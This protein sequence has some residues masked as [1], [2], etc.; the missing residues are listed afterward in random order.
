MIR[1][2][3]LQNKIHQPLKM[4]MMINQRQLHQ[5][6]KK[7]EAVA[8]DSSSSTV[9]NNHQQNKWNTT[10]YTSKMK[11]IDSMSDLKAYRVLTKEGDV[12]DPQHEP[13]DLTKDDLIHA[14]STMV[15]LHRMDHIMYEAQRQGRFSFYMTTFGEEA[16]IGVPMALDFKDMIHG[17][18]R[19]AYSLLYRGFSISD[20]MN[21]CFSNKDDGGK[22]RQ[23]MVHYTSKECNFQAIS[24]PLGTQIP[25]AS[26]VG[27][28]FKLNANNDR[29][30]VAFFG[31]GA[32]SEG[33]FHAGLNMAATLNCPVLFFCR[34]NGYAISTSTKEQYKGDGIASRGVGYGIDTIRV[35][36]NDVLAV[37][38]ATKAARQIAIQENKPVLI[39]AMTYRVGHHSTSDDS[40]KYR[41]RKEVEQ[42][43]ISDNPIHRF[44]N[45]LEKKNYW[46]QQKEDD[47]QLKVKQQVMEAFKIAE[48]KKKPNI[49]E[50]FTDVY[51]EL[52]PHLIRQKN[53]LYQLMKK[54]PEYYNTDDYEK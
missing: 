37:Y 52:P 21:Q 8:M 11:F 15:Q 14:Y 16:L 31:E 25:Q 24:S 29:I 32:A 50:L 45:Y 22:G 33:D 17:Q 1:L 49:D 43:K 53:E 12:I 20:C 4:M 27:Y 35:D 34:N 38:N 26:G 46:S 3:S 39:E 44:R 48:H 23:M 7:K 10:Q 42:H 2:T 5:S 36:G 51:D 30:S 18:Y 40:T 28:A 9:N 41:D 47:L 54:Y 13:K 19:E 6:F